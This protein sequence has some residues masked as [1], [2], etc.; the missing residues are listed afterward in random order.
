ME[1][2]ESESERRSVRS[3]ITIFAIQVPSVDERER[4]SG[5]SHIFQTVYVEQNICQRWLTYGANSK[6][7]G[8]K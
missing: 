7:K 5:Q 6:K 8:K 1:E 3:S 4:Q 2:E